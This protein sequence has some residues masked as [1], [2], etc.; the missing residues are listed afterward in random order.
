MICCP[1]V[2]SGTLLA[3][4]LHTYSIARESES[5]SK[6]STTLSLSFQF[7]KIGWLRSAVTNQLILLRNRA[8]VLCTIHVSILGS[9]QGALIVLSVKTGCVSLYASV[10]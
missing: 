10:H 2:K 5:E 7:R 9:H 4:V 8:I 3:R 6:S 1:E